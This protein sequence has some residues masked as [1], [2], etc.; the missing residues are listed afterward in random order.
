MIQVTHCICN[1]VTSRA[2]QDMGDARNGK[3]GK[4]EE[5]KE[6][7]RVKSLNVVYTYRYYD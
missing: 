4:K 2:K 3:S 1:D 5:K 7:G 6:H